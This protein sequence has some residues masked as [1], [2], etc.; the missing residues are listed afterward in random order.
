MRPILTVLLSILLIGSPRAA[1]VAIYNGSASIASQSDADRDSGLRA[2]F[3]QA[4]IKAS[5]DAGIAQ[6]PSLPGVIANAPA[7]AS[8]YTY[9][10]SVQPSAS[11]EAGLALQ[12]EAQ[13]DAAGVE[14]ALRALGRPLWGRE[15]PTALVWLVIDNNGN[16]QIASAFQQSALGALTATAQRRGLPI[17][18]PRMDGTDL[19]RIDPVTLWEAPPATII[20]ASQRYNARLIL[21]ARLQKVGDRWT[22]R[23]TLIDGLAFES[24]EAG[25]PATA[26]LLAGA[27]NGAVDRL[28]NRYAIDIGESALGPVTLWVEDVRS[29]ADFAVVVGYLGKLATV[30][31]VAPL[32]AEPGRLQLSMQLNAGLQRFRQTLSNDGVLAVESAAGS[33]DAPT[34]IVLRLA[35]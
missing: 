31:D 29:A 17:Q 2:A 4:L 35:H 10:E 9:S 18:L 24:W 14:N 6:D 32:A 34:P 8:H 1:E 12:I 33:A 21:V 28:S 30:T 7:M 26:D 25:A 15:R 23:Y 13:F 20:G 16:K 3:L 11:G 27:I 22:A 19:N 5:G